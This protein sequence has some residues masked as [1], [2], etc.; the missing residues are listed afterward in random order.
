MSTFSAVVVGILGVLVYLFDYVYR[1][2][3]FNHNSLRYT[4]YTVVLAT[5]VIPVVL[6]A[7]CNYMIATIH[8]GDGTFKKVFRSTIYAFSPYI[9][10]TPF[11]TILSMFL[12][13]DEGLYPD[14]YQQC[15]RGLGG[16]H[17]VPLY[18][19]GTG[20]HLLG[21]GQEHP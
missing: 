7:I 9:L 4:Q 20:F 12:T 10:I 11:T 18:Q 3:I 13:N 17:A 2:F 5:V 14:H 21:D 16:H 1:G 8:A 15:R 19:K 6:W